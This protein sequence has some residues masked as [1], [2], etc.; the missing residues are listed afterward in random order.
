MAGR[1]D[2]ALRQIEAAIAR[3][4][5][6]GYQAAADWYRLFLCEIY[7]AILSGEGGGS[8]GVLVRNIRSVAGAVLFGSQ[9]IQSLVETVR[10]NPQFDPEGH[11]VGRC[12][13]ILGLLFKTKKKKD[14]AAR[15]L[16]E[17]RRILIAFGPSPTLM[18]VET[19]LAALMGA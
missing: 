17:A 10:A 7:L 4:E 2:D 9:R 3:R 14:L 12:E 11:Y 1:I 19:A 5:K 15:H 18:R 13:M 6:E 16:T 8:L